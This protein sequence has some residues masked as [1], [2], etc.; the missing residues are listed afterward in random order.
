MQLTS[1]LFVDIVHRCR[2]SSIVSC[3]IAVGDV[4]PAFLVR[5]SE[6]REGGYLPCHYSLSIIDRCR[7]SVVVVC[8]ITDGNVAPA[9]CVNREDGQEGSHCPP[10]LM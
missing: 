4:V 9:F 5:K 2:R 8:H 3:H 6:G 10:G 1:T 7:D